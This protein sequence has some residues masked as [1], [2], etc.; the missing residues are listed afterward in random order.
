MDVVGDVVKD[1]LVIVIMVVITMILLTTRKRIIM[2]DKK[3]V[4]KIILQRLLRIY[5][6]DVYLVKLYQASI[7]KKGKHTETNF[8]SRNDEMETKDEDIHYNTKTDHVYE[9]DKFN[10]LNNITHLDVADFFENH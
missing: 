8:I 4:V 6:T 3:E 2:K 9:G 7:K 10:D 1:V 5:A